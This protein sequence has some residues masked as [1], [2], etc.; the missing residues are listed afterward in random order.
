MQDKAVEEMR[1]H[2]EEQASLLP[3]ILSGLGSL[4]DGSEDVTCFALKKVMGKREKGEE[5]N[6]ILG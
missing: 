2:I 4:L 5:R 3:E 1:K 6:V